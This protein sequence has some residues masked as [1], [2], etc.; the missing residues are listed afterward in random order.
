[1][2]HP[3]PDSNVWCALPLTVMCGAPTK[4]L[5]SCSQ[6][7]PVAPFD[8]SATVLLIGGAVIVSSW[9][10]NYGDSKHQHS[11]SHQFKLAAAAIMGGERGKGGGM[12]GYIG[13]GQGG[14]DTI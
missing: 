11:L 13:G 6:L 14:G 8:A 9:G 7:G 12:L 2:N 4:W 5:F 1:M 3:P 10:E